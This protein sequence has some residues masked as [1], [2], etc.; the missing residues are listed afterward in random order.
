MNYSNIYGNYEKDFEEYKKK[1]KPGT[2]DY[3]LYYNK[4]NDNV[5]GWGLLLTPVFF[6]FCNGSLFK[7]F[8]QVCLLWIGCI[9]LSALNNYVLNNDL[10]IEHKRKL[11]FEMYLEK[12]YGPNFRN[13][14]NSK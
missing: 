4:K 7:S 2:Y 9:L 12:K 11:C 5:L 3:Y 13:M 8:I 14:E 6:F 1:L 10:D